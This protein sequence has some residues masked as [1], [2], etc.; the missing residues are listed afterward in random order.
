ML[1]KA[2]QCTRLMLGSLS[3]PKTTAINFERLTRSK[4]SHVVAPPGKLTR[5]IKVRFQRARPNLNHHMPNPNHSLCKLA[6]LRTSIVY[7]L[8]DSLLYN[9]LV[10]TKDRP[11]TRA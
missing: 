8:P 1:R 11:R 7:L 10:V 3:A 4:V 5:A 2:L 9:E 6:R